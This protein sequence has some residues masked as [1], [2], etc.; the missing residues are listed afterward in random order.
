M[1]KRELAMSLV[2]DEA[3]VDKKFAKDI[4]PIL[5]FID[6]LT[7]SQLDSLL[8]GIRDHFIPLRLQA[9]WKAV[10]PEEGMRST[11]YIQERHPLLY[12]SRVMRPAQAWRL[13]IRLSLLFIS[14]CRMNTA[15]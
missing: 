9:R 14:S 13:Q 8:E 6:S 7:D 5:A 1:F 4:G 2:Q 11:T 15:A 10:C 12:C 3:E